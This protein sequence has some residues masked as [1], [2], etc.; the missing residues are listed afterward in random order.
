MPGRGVGIGALDLPL[1][2]SSLVLVKLINML[3]SVAHFL[4]ESTSSGAQP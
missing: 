4:M 1:M 2:T 3:F